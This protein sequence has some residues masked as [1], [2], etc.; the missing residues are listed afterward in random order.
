MTPL[1][2]FREARLNE[3]LAAQ[4]AIVAHDP[5]NINEQLF[6]CALLAFEGDRAAVRRHLDLI[7][8]APPELQDHLAEWRDL[9]AADNTR[10]AGCRPVHRHNS[11]HFLRRL[12]VFDPKVSRKRQVLCTLD[13]ADEMAPWIEGH[14][15]G[16]SFDGW[17]DMD[18]LIGPT[19]E[20]FEDGQYLWIPM[21]QVRKLRLEEPT[22]LRDEIYRPAKLWLREGG[23]RE[24]FLPVLYVGTSDHEEEGIRTGAGVDWVER[25]GIMRGVGSRTFL[26]GDEEL[27]FDE[28]R[29]VETR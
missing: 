14:V 2:L 26:F 25:K 21:D 5:A 13:D 23:A 24:V 27:T 12:D 29:Q 6:L 7:A 20:V 1:E 22:G 17:R 11:A 4:R 10:H 16:R 15:D 9:L 18:D 8:D 19:L 3:A 28:F